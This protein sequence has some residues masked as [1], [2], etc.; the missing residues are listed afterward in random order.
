ML[1]AAV[2][3]L[4]MPAMEHA[5]KLGI[6][7]MIPACGGFLLGALF[8]FAIDKCLPHLHPISKVQ[9]GPN[10]HF[11]DNFLLFTAITIHNIP[12]GLALGVI[13]SAAANLGS[14][15][16]ITSTMILA[17]GIGI[18]NIPEGTAVSMPMF[19][20]GV[21]KIK[22]FVMAA[23]SGITEPIAAI[24]A[25]LCLGGSM[26]VFLP[27]ALSFSAGAM[28]Y[29]VCEELIPQSHKDAGHT[30]LATMSVLLGFVLMMFLDI[31]LS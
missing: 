9:D 3:G 10:V 26:T 19:V 28:L 7:K 20:S 16:L 25:V 27:W 12:E 6:N 30:D 8:L 21:S 29:V 1:A 2:W 22:S 5:Q 24:V 14:S 18:Q 11:N 23:L 15:D 17:L 4:L 31:T 13:V